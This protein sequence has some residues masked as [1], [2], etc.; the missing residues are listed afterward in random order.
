MNSPS[1]AGLELLDTP[2]LITHA[3]GK[4]E[5]ANPACENLLAIGRRELLRHSL[6][7]LLQDSPALRQALATAC[8][9][10]P[11]ISSTISNC[12]RR[13]ASSHCI[14]PCRSPRL[15]PKA[16]WRW[17]SCGHWISN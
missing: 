2:V 6:F 13:M 1:F 11:A 17:S 4:L 7:E 15:M 14:S 8:N 9:T 16:G 3:D 12:A 5:F 10:T